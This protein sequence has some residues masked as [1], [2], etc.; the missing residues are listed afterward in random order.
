MTLAEAMTAAAMAGCRL[1][2]D[3]QGGIALVVPDGAALARQVLEVL[4]A[5]REQIAAAHA[6][7]RPSADEVVAVPN[8]DL[9]DYLREQGISDVG[10]EFVELA[11]RV[12]EVR[13]ERITIE[14][15]GD[16]SEPVL[17]EPGIPILTTKATKWHRP[18]HGYFEIPAGTLGLAIPQPWAIADDHAR[19]IVV[20]TI[21]AAAKQGRRTHM[22]VWLEGDARTLDVDSFTFEGAVAPP[23]LDLLPWRTVPG[24]SAA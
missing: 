3:D 6:G 5:N 11:A 22:A 4:R 18:R 23:G 13:G 20:A 12:F 24:A 15:V 16:K 17:F 19:G 9:A 10:I 8:A 14:P 21:E 7:P 1:V 2:P